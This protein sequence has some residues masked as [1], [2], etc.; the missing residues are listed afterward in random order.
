LQKIEVNPQN[1]RL[2]TSG[3]NAGKNRCTIIP[4]Q[5]RSVLGQAIR[6]ELRSEDQA[7]VRSMTVESRN[8]LKFLDDALVKC[9]LQC[10]RENAVLCL[11]IMGEVK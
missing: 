5:S 1:D 10:G 11:R 4:K 2:E 8:A 6:A 7:R 9:L 3:I